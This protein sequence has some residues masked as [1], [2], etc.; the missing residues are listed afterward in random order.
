MAPVPTIPIFAIFMAFSFAALII[1][2]AILSRSAAGRWIM[3][4]GALV[5]LMFLGGTVL[6]ARAQPLIPALNSYWITIHV[7]AAIIAT[8]ILLV[9]GVASVQYLAGAPAG[10][11]I[12]ARLPE[13]AVEAE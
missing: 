8:G 4:L 5:V 13:G 12:G 7:T 11:R 10:S 9:S 3:G 6:Y 2:C 1:V